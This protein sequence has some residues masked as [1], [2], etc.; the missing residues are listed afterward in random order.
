[1]KFVVFILAVT[2]CSAQVDRDWSFQAFCGH[3]Q[4][5]ATYKPREGYSS[6]S[7]DSCSLKFPMA[8]ADEESA[9]QYCEE[10]VPYHINEAV[11][12]S[13]TICKAEATLICKAEWVQMFGRCYK[14]KKVM[15]TREEADAH[16]K[17]EQASIAYLHRHALPFRFYEYFTHVSQIWLE[18]SE[19]ITSDL[20]YDTPGGNLILAFDGYPYNLPNIA[21]AR[22]DPTQKAMVLCEYTP[23]MTQAE[24]T[25]LLRRY[26]E[27]YYPTVFTSEG[28]YVRTA[29]SLNR[30]ENDNMADNKY[31]SRVLAPFVPGG[32]A[33]SAI[34]TREFLDEVKRVNRNDKAL[35]IRTSAF[36]QKADKSKRVQSSCVND[37]SSVFHIY[38][39]EKAGSIKIGKSEWMAGEPTGMCDAASWSSAVVMSR[40]GSPG[41]EAMSD[42]R[43]APIYCQSIT[44]VYAYGD[45]PAGFSVYERKEL[46]QRWCHKLVVDLMTYDDAERNCQTMGAH[47]S[48]FSSEDEYKFLA[49]LMGPRY[50]KHYGTMEVFLGAKRR[51]QCMKLGTGKSRGYEKDVNHTCSRNRVFEWKNNVAPNPPV[52]DNFWMSSA[53]PNYYH[54][55]EICLVMIKRKQGD[56]GTLNDI[57]CAYK[58]AHFCGKEAPIVKVSS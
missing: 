11:P 12:G 26:G 6:L 33:Q 27:I 16:C 7:G 36:S 49:Q 10:Q 14:M 23:A 17:K 30:N 24:S 9:R 54:I 53:E 32:K 20:I 1:M 8:T 56:K 3:W 29:S 38:S 51:E 18:A 4:G 5:N 45:C 57:G 44:D 41:L 48:G 28:A 50:S 37:Q 25:Y 46:G 40:E 2:L 42:A 47:L 19:A 15:M 55:D 31:C 43:Y 34:P 21:L 35:I 58:L 22:V 39:L 13:E 52:T